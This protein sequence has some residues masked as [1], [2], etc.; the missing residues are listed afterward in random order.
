MSMADKILGWSQRFTLPVA[1]TL[2]NPRLL[3]GG[4][5]CDYEGISFPGQVTNQWTSSESKLPWMGL[6]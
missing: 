6:P 5:T 3:T 2:N 1:P 4:E